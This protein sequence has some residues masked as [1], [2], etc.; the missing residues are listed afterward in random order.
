MPIPF[1]ELRAREFGRLDAGGHVYLDYTG[2]GLHARSQ[3]RRHLELLED[4][5]L[6]NPHSRN[7]SSMAATRMVEEVR[8]RVLRYFDADPEEYELAF[9]LNATA[10][11]KLIGESYPFGPGS[12]FALTADNHNSVHG[13]RQYAAARGA[14]VRY[15][16]LNE[17]LRVSGL[18]EELAGADPDRSHLFVFP[19]QSNFSGVKHPLEWIPR[20]QE[21]GYDVA[22]DAAAFVPTSRL[23]LREVHP[24][25]VCVSFY[26]MFGYPT[27]VGALLARRRALGKLCRPWFGG[28]TVRF[29]S[30]RSE[31]CLPYGTAR[32]F[33]DGTVNFLGI[34]A[35]P[36]GLDFMEEVGVERINRHVMELTALL[37]RELQSLRHGSGTPLV[38]VYGPTGLEGRGGTVAFN[39]LDREGAPVDFRVVEERAGAEGISLRT[40]YFCNPGAAEF[41]FGHPGEDVERC[42][43]AMT[44]ESFTLEQ[45][46]VCIGDRPVGAVRASLGVASN[47]ADVLK[48]MRLLETFRDVENARELDVPARTG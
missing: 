16:P 45:F 31:V 41:A 46:S 14:E 20:A 39:V 9:V 22:L 33:E 6:G 36:I 24:D 12:R 27:G 2:S 11:L 5:V 28:G 23:S 10:A 47:E 4:R 1:S 40:G 42:A 25:F 37:L 32:G 8:A 30:A 29:V 34:A 35:V 38:R 21:L 3:L 17:E 43:D 7:P 13:I 44:P 26:K 48:L 19:A 15:V 18:E